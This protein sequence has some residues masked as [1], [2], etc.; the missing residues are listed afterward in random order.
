M[1]RSAQVFER[2]YDCAPKEGNDLQ[3]NGTAKLLVEKNEV[4]SGWRLFS[5]LPELVRLTAAKGRILGPR[6]GTKVFGGDY[7]H[8]CAR[9]TRLL[10]IFT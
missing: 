4:A 8:I 9:K 10:E 6:S 2:H 1:L 7:N 5:S 3:K